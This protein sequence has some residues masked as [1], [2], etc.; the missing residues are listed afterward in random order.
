MGPRDDPSCVKGPGKRR[1][2]FIID[3]K[4]SE[5]GQRRVDRGLT[6]HTPCGH[7]ESANHRAHEKD[8]GQKNEGW[9][10]RMRRGG[11][12]RITL[13]VSTED[14]QLAADFRLAGERQVAAE[15]QDIAIDRTVE[16]NI[17]REGTHAAAAVP[18]DGDGAQVAA[19]CPERLFRPY[20]NIAANPYK[21]WRQ[22][23][24]KQDAKN[25]TPWKHAIGFLG[26]LAQLHH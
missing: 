23:R 18:F 4:I 21:I 9:Q 10:H 13:Q 8:D 2:L 1:A 19:D 20:G 7:D 12:R 11:S 5:P 22:G 14:D 15:D 16:E 26:E 25:E 17:P 3:G 6:H 24:E